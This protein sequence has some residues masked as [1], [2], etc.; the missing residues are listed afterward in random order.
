MM[1]LALD[2]RFTKHARNRRLEYIF[3]MEVHE[4][5]TF[6]SATAY[7]YSQLLKKKETSLEKLNFVLLPCRGAQEGCSLWIRLIVASAH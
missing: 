2:Q 6:V 7:D 3:C 1:S 5:N 4:R